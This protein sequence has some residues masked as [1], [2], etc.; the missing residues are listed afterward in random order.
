MR[1]YISQE[2][3]NQIVI[4]VT[5]SSHRGDGKRFFLFGR[6]LLN[7]ASGRVSKNRKTNPKIALK[8]LVKRGYNFHGVFDWQMRI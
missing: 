7:G 5:Y 6:F 4:I 8:S 1:I 2:K 3:I